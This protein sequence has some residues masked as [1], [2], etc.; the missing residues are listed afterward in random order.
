MDF[1]VEAFL[2]E[3]KRPASVATVTAGGR[4]ALATMWYLFADDRFW[5]HS[6]RGSGPFIRAAAN[7]DPVAVMVETFDPTGRVIQVRSTGPATIQPDDHDRIH[8]I[9]DRYLGLD[10]LWSDGWRRQAADPTFA[11]WSI[12]PVSG[13]AVQ[14]PELRDA[15]GDFRWSSSAEF[16]SA[17][18]A[19]RRR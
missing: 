17:L 4:P 9:Y 13:A 18:R 2:D 15:G 19:A 10:G 12:E 11:L 6:P 7:H 8:Q 16:R 3:P 14:F 1:D 5:L